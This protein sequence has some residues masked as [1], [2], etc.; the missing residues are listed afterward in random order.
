M[1]WVSSST[2]PLPVLLDICF[3]SF[4]HSRGRSDS[5][6]SSILW[7]SPW[8]CSSAWT[9]R[10][11]NGP[12]GVLNPTPLS[13]PWLSLG[14]QI[15]VLPLNCPIANA[16]V[17]NAPSLPETILPSIPLSFLIKWKNIY[18]SIVDLQCCIHFRC[19][20][21][22]FSYTYIYICVCVYICIHIYMYVC[23]CVYIYVYI[24]VCVYIHISD[25]FPL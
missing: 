19:T 2:E 21:K 20:A 12:Q 15:L 22:W 24:C 17:Q 18:W 5:C 7:H 9:P 1:G 3:L 16:E 4:S 14:P 11:W 23:I 8:P 10:N 25:S 6:N 13:S